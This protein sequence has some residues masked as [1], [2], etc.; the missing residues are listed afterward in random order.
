MNMVHCFALSLR[1]FG[2]AYRDAPII[3]TVGDTT[4][5]P[6]LHHRHPWLG[7]RGVNVRWVPEEDFRIHSY[8]A[9]GAARFVHPYR[10]DVVLFLDADIL[11][12]SAFDEL[13]A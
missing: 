11:V 8:F 1:R 4:I 12:T 2:G 6:D 9:T 7:R 10:S 5:D 13:D 3:L